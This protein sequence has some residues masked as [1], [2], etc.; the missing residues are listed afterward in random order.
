M[1]S[2]NPVESLSAL[3]VQGIVLGCV[4]SIAIPISRLIM[5]AEFEGYKKVKKL[6]KKEQLAVGGA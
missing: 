6:M 2:L 1:N 5:K 4:I 3:I